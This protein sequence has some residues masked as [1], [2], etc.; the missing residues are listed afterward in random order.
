MALRSSNAVNKTLP[1]KAEENIFSRSAVI[2]HVYNNVL[3]NYF[4][5]CGLSGKSGVGAAAE[6][7]V[8]ISIFCW[9]RITGRW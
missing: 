9:M 6:V 7:F 2:L 1:V 3:I 8:S 4:S 5:P